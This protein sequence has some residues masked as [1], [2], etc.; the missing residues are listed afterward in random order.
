MQERGLDGVSTIREANNRFKKILE[1]IKVLN[2]KYKN[3][4]SHEEDKIIINFVSENPNNISEALIKASNKLNRSLSSITSR[5][6]NLR[7]NYNTNIL[8]CVY[9][10]KGKITIN[11]KNTKDTITLS[12]EGSK[13]IN[14]ILSKY[15]NRS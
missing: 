14:I 12:E 3:K 8:F 13:I 1:N 5:W 11:K 9:S 10:I 7:K 4:Y 15:G 2:I 6:Y